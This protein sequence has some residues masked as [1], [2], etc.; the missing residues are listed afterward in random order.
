MFAFPPVF[1]LP[2]RVAVRARQ[3][4]ARFDRDKINL[5]SS[6]FAPGTTKTD[7]FSPPAVVLDSGGGVR[8]RRTGG[9]RTARFA[10]DTCARFV[11]D[12]HAEFVACDNGRLRKNRAE[13]ERR[14]FA[15]VGPGGGIAA[16]LAGLRC[17]DRQS[18]Y[19][20]QRE[21]AVHRPGDGRRANHPQPRHQKRLGAGD[22]RYADRTVHP[23]E[24][25]SGP[26]HLRARLGPV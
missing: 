2:L 7:H 16:R 17:A 26:D 25:R 23:S 20:R 19:V 4:A 9:C 22:H 5:F 15:V 10:T 12:H 1:C 13:K 8:R 11:T 6:D 24:I 3:C 21:G 18:L 14:R